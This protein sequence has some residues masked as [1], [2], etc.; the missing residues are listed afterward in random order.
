[1]PTIPHD[2][3]YTPDATA[4]RCIGDL[5]RISGMRGDDLFI[6]PSAGAFCRHLPQ[7]H[8]IALDIKPEAVGIATGDVLD[9]E[10]PEL[11]G[12]RIVI[13]N[14]PFGRNGMLA[15]AFM[16]QAMQFA[17]IVAFIL[18]ASYAKPSMQRGIDRHYHLVHQANLPAQVFETSDG[19]QR[20][21]TV[22]QIWER[23]DHLRNADA[24]LVSQFHFAFV[25]D[26]SDAD[27]VIRRVGAWAGSCRR[28][29]RPPMAC[30]RWDVR[31]VRIITS[32]PLIAILTCWQRGSPQ[33]ISQVFRGTPFV[34]R[35]PSAS[36]SLP[37]SR[38]LAM[39]WSQTVPINS[40]GQR[41]PRARLALWLGL[42]RA[43][44][45]GRSL[46]SVVQAP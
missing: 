20:V 2:K 39:Q 19:E 41:T 31:Q 26:I 14:P 28:L 27:L 37:M 36:W 33:W 22:F 40:S 23:R 38:L 3:F 25:K 46:I 4:R 32:R 35:C 10:A 11:A 44:G 30:F 7:D 15:R 9:F 16:R 17:D 12:R 34:R 43:P 8:L 18:P 6:E 24:G 5:W 45:D 1:M 42:R 13:G 21:N 29:P